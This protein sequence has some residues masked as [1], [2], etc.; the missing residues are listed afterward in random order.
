MELIINLT[1]DFGYTKNR[2]T[3]LLLD[4]MG[5]GNFSTQYREVVS[6]YPANGFN[7]LCIKNPAI[8]DSVVSSLKNTKSRSGTQKICFI[9]LGKPRFV[10]PL[11]NFKYVLLY[12]LF[13]AFPYSEFWSLFKFTLNYKL[14][15]KHFI[16]QKNFDYENFYIDYL[17]MHGNCHEI[18]FSDSLQFL[19]RLQ[20]LFGTS[21]ALV[22]LSRSICI[23]GSVTN[24]IRIHKEEGKAIIVNNEKIYKYK[25]DELLVSMEPAKEC[26]VPATEE[27]F[28]INYRSDNLG[29]GFYSFN[30]SVCV[31]HFYNEFNPT[32]LFASINSLESNQ[33]IQKII[34]IKK[35]KL[36]YNFKFSGV[37]F[38]S[39]M[40]LFFL[41]IADKDSII[42]KLRFPIYLQTRPDSDVKSVAP[43]V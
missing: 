34:P 20:Q 38:M 28:L 13:Q 35:E 31:G 11:Y 21:V 14:E 7:N 37:K 4:Q 10:R 33:Y 27:V 2:R 23:H 12:L 19:T 17:Q 32:M 29:N 42:R 36:T 24:L 6:I 25:E 1:K 26:G 30:F 5:V 15:S 39:G 43:Y 40:Y 8:Y 16:D 22:Y 9:S 3:R 18:Y 41:N